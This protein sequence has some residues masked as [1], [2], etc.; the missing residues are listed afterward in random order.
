MTILEYILATNPTGVE[1]LLR[2]FGFKIV[3]RRRRIDHN[4][5]VDSYVLV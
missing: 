5:T 1:K 2:Y 3:P 4:N